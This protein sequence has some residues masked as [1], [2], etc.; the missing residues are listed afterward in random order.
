MAQTSDFFQ[1]TTLPKVNRSSSQN[2]CK[3]HHILLPPAQG[4]GL[5]GYMGMKPNI[6]GKCVVNNILSW[7]TV[8]WEIAYFWLCQGLYG[9][10]VHHQYRITFHCEQQFLSGTLNM[11]SYTQS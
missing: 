10:Q 9:L 1:Q 8:D 11:V 4:S 6:V 7:I 3:V 5:I 2:D